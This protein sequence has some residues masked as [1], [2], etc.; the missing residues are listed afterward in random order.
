MKLSKLYCNDNRFKEVIFNN[1]FNVILGEISNINDLNK[2]SHNLGKSTLIYIIDFMLLKEID[3]NHFLKS[4]KFDD[5]I[6]FMEL[7]LNSGK[8]LTIKRSVRNNTKISLKFHENCKQ[9]YIQCSEWDYEDLPLTTEDLSRNPK[10]VIERAL[11]FD[12]LLNEDYR[13]TS[14]YFL[15]T[16]DDYNDV[17]KLQKHRGK[18]IYWKPT[19]Y[20]LLGFSSDYMID[21]YILENEIEIKTKLIEKAR[22]DFKIDTGEIDKI[23]GMI[24]IKKNQRDTIISWLDKFDF[25]QKESNISR[26]VL[27][28][29]EK[30]ISSLNTKRFNLDFEIQQINESLKADVKYNLDDIIQIYK[31]V[32]VNFPDYLVKSYEELL[33]FNKKV[34]DERNTYLSQSLLDKISARE[35]VDK[36]LQ[37]LNKKRCALLEGLTET[38]T[39]GKYNKYRDDLIKIERELE[40][41]YAELDSIDNVNLI[42]KEINDIK[43]KL[44]IATTQ[45]KE[46]VEK[47]SELYKNIRRDFHDYVKTILDHTAMISIIINTND[48]VD[49]EAK[50]FNVNNE[51]T[52]QSLGH[53]YKKILCACFDLAIIKNYANKSFYRFIYHDGCLESLDPRKQKKYLDLV[54]KVSKECNIQYILTCLKSEIPDEEAYQIKPNEIAV[55]LSD[56]GNDEGRLFGFAF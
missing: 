34:S 46:Q 2:D 55:T 6:F 4:G 47:S 18:D 14:G 35:E 5:Y 8:F 13:K 44:N 53:S 28:D 45:L 43:N 48:N 52:A 36:K 40:R 3:K 7:M 38:E 51:E 12:V 11:D 37:E 32:K 9:D 29:I 23:H 54:R 15:R 21:K 22:E 20:E 56:I 25:Y 50:F 10:Q 17:F 1:N 31:E 26:E 24:D 33:E 27:D 41:H 42:K 19:L 49:F 39:F 30:G 16:Q